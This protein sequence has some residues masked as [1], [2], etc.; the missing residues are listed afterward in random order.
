MAVSLGAGTVLL[1]GRTAI[2]DEKLK[3]S[4]DAWRSVETKGLVQLRVLVVE[5]DEDGMDV[6]ETSLYVAEGSLMMMI[7][8]LWIM[9]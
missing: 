9:E 2:E 1:L 5:A 7:F 3:D 6:Q 8:L 4:H